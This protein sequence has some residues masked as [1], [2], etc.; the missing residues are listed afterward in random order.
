MRRPFVF[1]VILLCALTGWP[2]VPTGHV[3]PSPSGDLLA[4]GLADERVRV[5]VRR[6]MGWRRRRR[7]RH[8]KSTV[9]RNRGTLDSRTS[10]EQ[11]F[12]KRHFRLSAGPN[13]LWFRPEK[14][15]SAF[16]QSWKIDNNRYS[17]ADHR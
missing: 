11:A 1:L 16:Q 17:G 8:P 7:R 15:R 3:G 13:R 14:R 4:P 10:T 5:S 2:A 12:V 6:T 9:G